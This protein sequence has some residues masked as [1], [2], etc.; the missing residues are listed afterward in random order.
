MAGGMSAS[1]QKAYLAPFVVFMGLLAVGEAVAHLFEGQD[2]WFASAPR[3]W[4]FPLQTVVCGILLARYWRHYEWRAP[5][6]LGF[7]IAV[8]VFV[9]VLW[10]SPQIF[11][12]SPPRT[13]GFDPG[14]FGGGWAFALNVTVRFIRLVIVVP[15]LEE[16]FW[17]GFLLRYLIRE[18]FESVPLGTFSWSSFLWVTVFFG[19]AH[20]GGGFWP[21]GPDFV[22]ALATGML[23]NAVA[24][25][26]KSLS[27]CVLAHA[28]TNALLGIYIL[29]TGQWGFW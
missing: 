9:F 22:P 17:R 7:T 2:I 3:Y 12:G 27:S 18:P 4:V 6:R 25:R 28:I 1:L 26:T 16:I 11:F 5:A 19:L 29:R 20:Y 15:L 13:D 8:A 10:I 23:Y 24:Y 21:P 14:Y